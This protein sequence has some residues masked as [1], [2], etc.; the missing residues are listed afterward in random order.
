[1][2]GVTDL[3]CEEKIRLLLYSEEGGLWMEHMCSLR[4]PSYL[5]YDGMVQ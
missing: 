4:A 2:A 1:M 3:D 5:I